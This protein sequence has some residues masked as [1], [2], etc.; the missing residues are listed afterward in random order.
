M[1]GQDKA[2]VKLRPGWNLL[3]VKV[4]QCTGPWSFCARLAQPDGSPL[5][6]LVFDCLRE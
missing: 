3:L 4:T 6:G 5:P 2:N 1:P